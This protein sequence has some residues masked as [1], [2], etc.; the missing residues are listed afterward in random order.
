MASAERLKSFATNDGA[1][2]SWDDNFEGD[3]TVRCPAN[4]PRSPLKK[5]FEEDDP[6]MQTIRPYVQ[7]RPSD[8]ELPDTP[9]LSR[10]NTAA[11]PEGS[12]SKH[13]VKSRKKFSALPPAPNAMGPGRRP[14]S[15]FREDGSEDYSDLAPLN[16]SS[17]VKKVD[18]MKKDASLSPRLFHPSDLKNSL[19]RSSKSSQNGGSTRRMPA[20]FGDTEKDTHRMRRSR[21]TLEIEKF[22]E[23]EGEEDYSDVFGGSEAGTDE[24][25][26][27][28][29]GDE[30]QSLILNSKLSNNSWLGDEGDEDDP[31]AE[32]EEG[33]DEMDLE[34][35]IARDKYARLCLQI[36]VLV[37][38]LK[39]TQSEDDLDDISLQLMEILLESPETK[40][41]VISA[42]GMLPILEVLE[43]CEQREVVAKLLKIVNAVSGGPI[44]F[45]VGLAALT[46]TIAHIRRS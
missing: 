23:A 33:F 24:A 21:S 43:T 16:E 32:L 42:H 2:E 26:S 3:L 1:N 44:W 36:D 20:P 45:W 6:N 27:E 19:P 40:A 31:F 4:P 9:E 37:S 13:R 30:Q 34:A 25:G 12:P 35:N 29:S 39:T 22:A 10:P 7:R 17:F 11:L 5:A 38:S 14:P 8:L 15:I 28:T 46:N 18:L 41:N